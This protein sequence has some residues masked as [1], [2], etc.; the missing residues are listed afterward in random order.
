M[1]V[2]ESLRQLGYRRC[3]GSSEP[4]VIKVIVKKRLLRTDPADNDK[5]RSHKNDPGNRKHANVPHR[6]PT[7]SDRITEVQDLEKA[8]PGQE[9]KHR[10]MDV[11]AHGAKRGL[12]ERSPV[13]QVKE[14]GEQEGIAGRELHPA[15][16]AADE[17]ETAHRRGCDS[18]NRPAITEQ[19]PE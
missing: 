17:K 8:E 2:I 1:F 16:R 18:D 13:F 11:V 6:N 19:F 5:P 7:A 9:R 4:R 12:K 15:S 10:A 3:L 14:K